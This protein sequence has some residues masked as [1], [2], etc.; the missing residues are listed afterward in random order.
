MH[1]LIVFTAAFVA[2]AI[3][4]MA[5]GGTLISFPALIW[6][7]LPSVAA[8]AT[9]TV[10]LCPGSLGSLWGYQSELKGLDRRLYALT[11][12]SL[13]G[14]LAG[15]FLL[16]RTP[17]AVFDRLVP[18]LILFAT[19]LFLA[20]E[21][22]Q[23]RFN[24]HG[25]DRRSHWLAWALLYQLLVGLYGGYFGAGI[26]ILMLAAL[27][28]MGHSDIHQMNALKT[29]LALCMNGVAAVYFA[30]S[31]LVFW[32]DALLMA[33]GAIAGG[34]GGV[35]LARQM[36]RNAVRRVVVITGFAMAFSLMLR[37]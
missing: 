5:G 12:P 21:P 19:L 6:A 26:G 3:N 13:I 23:R 24:L 34:I 2:G 28:I 9:N 14:G 35:R 25:H 15:A 18:I 32:P 8:N 7:G 31:G 37:L 17:T 29:L 22:I 4:S 27:S 36:G 20:Q 11:A 1:G 10:A 30:F 16:A 33:I